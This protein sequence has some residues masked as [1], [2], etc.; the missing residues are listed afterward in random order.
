MM[1]LPY[2]AKNPPERFPYAT[3]GLIAANILVYV[4]TTESLWVVRDSAVQALAFS[5][6]HLTLLRMVTAMF[7]HEGPMHLIG[8]MLFLW[9][10]GTAAEG[11]LGPIR[12]LGLYLLA[13]LFGDLI[14]AGTMGLAHPREWNLGASGSIMGIAGAYLYMFPFATINVVWGYGLRLGVAE[15]QA[16]WVILY[17]LGFD[18]VNAILYQGLDGV[19]HLVHLGGAAF[20]FFLPLLLKIPRDHEEASDAQAMRVNARGDYAVLAIHELEALI[21]NHPGDIRLLMTFCQKASVRGEVQGP[22]RCMEVLVRHGAALIAQADPETLAHL[23]LTL[24]EQSGPAPGSLLMRLGAKLE[25]GGGYETAIRCFERVYKNEPYGR[26]SETALARVARLTETTNS[27]RNAAARVYATLLSHFPNGPQSAY[28]ENSLRRLGIARPAEF[29]L[30]MGSAAAPALVVTPAT[31][32]SPDPATNSVP[33]NVL[34]TPWAVSN[35][36][37]EEPKDAPAPSGGMAM[38]RPMGSPPSS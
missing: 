1:V 8:N 10:F 38:L 32:P 29:V 6:H 12:F 28:A 13:G 5:N 18:L 3:L 33:Q 23:I 25:A 26:D 7:L 15:W 14:Q 19:G 35:F 20:G 30:S 36:A 2:R 16:Q 21:E 9:I 31:T 24:P 27:D 11:R 34:A 37:G 22:R 4:A 17:F